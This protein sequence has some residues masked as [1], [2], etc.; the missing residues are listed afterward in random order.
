MK[1][2]RQKSVLEL[3]IIVLVFL[4]LLLSIIFLVVH[5]DDKDKEIKS[6]KIIGTI[7][8]DEGYQLKRDIIPQLEEVFNLNNEEI[9]TQL[10][11]P[12][13]SKLI[14]EKISDWKKIEGLI[15]PGIY[16]IPEGRTLSEE[17]EIWLDFSEKRIE[18]LSSELKNL[19][20]LATREQLA[21]ASVISAECLNG[22]NQDKT[23]EVFLNRLSNGD[24]LQSCVTVEYA[25]GYQRP[26]LLFSD[27]EINSPY[28]TYMNFGLPPGPIC[29][30]STESLRAAM[31]KQPSSKLNYFFYDYVLNEM[32]FFSDYQLF[33][34][35]GA[36]AGE[37]FKT[38]QNLDRHEKINKQELYHKN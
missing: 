24:K 10:A 31:T 37:R 26:Y 32:F 15:P 3:L 18:T 19:N 23:A 25:L 38:E 8:I 11:L 20:S 29:A 27:L 13:K 36:L 1:A 28:N 14:P 16:E 34:E 21:L 7:N 9:L 30:I 5:N 6:I 17:I 35:E 2:I 33:Q 4:L 12:S 22:D